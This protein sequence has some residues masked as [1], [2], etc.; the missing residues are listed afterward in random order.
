MMLLQGLVGGGESPLVMMMMVVVKCLH[1]LVPW[2]FPDF[3]Y[4]SRELGRLMQ[5]VVLSQFCQEPNYAQ[6]SSRGAFQ[7]FMPF[8]F[9]CHP[10]VQVLGGQHRGWSRQFVRLHLGHGHP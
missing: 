2:C 9:I 6:V 3:D 4:I 8:H 1:E 7:P 5:A 10:G